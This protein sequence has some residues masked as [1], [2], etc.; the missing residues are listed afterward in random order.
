MKYICS[1]NTKLVKYLHPKT[2]KIAPGGNFQAFNDNWVSSKLTA[3][4]IAEQVK[5][6]TGLCA[7]H[8]VE[9]KRKKESTQLI[10]AGLII[11]DIDNQDDGKDEEGNKIQK[12]ELTKEQALELDICKK[13]LTVA[14]DSPSTTE[15]WPRFR[16]IFGLENSILDAEFYQWFSRSICAAIPG[17]DRRA[18]QC[19]NLFYGGKDENSV[20]YIS[21]NFIP[22]EKINEAYQHYLTLPKENKGD[23]ADPKELLQDLKTSENGLDIKHLLSK[24]V[25]DVL[26]GEPV[27]DRSATMAVVFKELI[28]W[29]NW[30][31]EAGLTVK[32]S[33]L[34]VAQDAFYAIYDYPSDL[35]GKFERILSSIQ[36]PTG[37][38]PAIALASENGVAAVWKRVRKHN[39]EIYDQQ[40]PEEIKA[41]LARIKSRPANSILNIEDFSLQQSKQAPVGTTTTKTSKKQEQSM[42]VPQNPTQLINLQSNSGNERT[43]SE[44]DVADI[45]VINQ[46]DDFVYDSTLDQFYTYDEDNGTWYVQDEQHIKRRI[47][48][49]LDT[50]VTAGVLPK[51]TSTTVSSVFMLLKGKLLKSLDG[52]RK[53]I[54]SKS[55]NFIPFNNGLLDINTLEFEEGKHKEFYLRHRLGYD[56]DDTAKCPKFL[57]WLESALDKDKTIIIQAFCRALLTGYT[58]GERFLHLVGPGGTGKSTLQQVLI[59]MAGF[60]GTHTS[61]LEIIETNKFECHNLIGK[62]L[63]LLTD[64][65]N[66]NKRMDVMKKLTS[67]SDT[68]RAERKY[69]KEII[70]FKPECLV[71][72]AS[73]EHITSSDPSSGLERRRLTLIMDKVVPA[74]NRKE[75]LS[76]Y[77]DRIIGEFVPELSGIVSWALSLPHDDM[78]DVLA[79]PTKHS[80][81]LNQTNMEALMFNN[82]FVAWMAECCLYAPNSSTPV[83]R[84][85]CKPS[86]DESER[87][88][89]VKDAYSE[90]YASYVNFC[91]ACGYK[92]AAKPRF[93]DRTKEA[94]KNILKLPKCDAGIKNGIPVFYGL[95]LKPYDLTSDAAAYGANRLP[96]PIEYAANPDSKIWETAFITHDNAQTQT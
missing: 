37:L 12:Q 26:N 72:I 44:N 89:Y 70:N 8:L 58:A 59:A 16:L 1:V 2:G 96:N 27:E 19:P 36:E 66:Y 38:Q 54:W 15:T 43:F 48:K 60:N 83:G 74:S 45:I 5:K 71:C 95:R 79:N 73:N 50:F 88:L 6:K 64:E 9:G 61:S 40:A 62:R 31:A 69:G 41:A 68:L 85:A 90:L 11:I 49:A 13:Y 42:K 14:Y 52:G 63:L 76:V 87:G 77:D 51:Y 80:P 22:S 10:Q 23:N 92:Q 67:A 91:K 7:W 65:S 28:G 75:L 46:G 57:N 4:E 84:G 93:V 82:Q 53:T 81:S 18:T 55:K 3:E 34:T 39:R 47:I 78:R 17:S 94:V 25:L 86:T 20:F 21:D 30:V 33:L 29:R 35:D 32:D 24:K 56:Y